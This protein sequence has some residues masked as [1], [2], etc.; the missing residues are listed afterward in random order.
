MQVD[1]GRHA[2]AHAGPVVQI[3]FHA[4]APGDGFQMDHRVGR[5][6]DRRVDANS[7]FEGFL[8]QDLRQFQV[9][10]DH[11]HGTHAGHVRQHIAARIHGW[12]RRVVG[13][14]SAE[15]F[16][17]AGHGRGGAHGVAGTGRAG[18]AALGREEIVDADGAGLDL[19]A[20]LPDHGAGANVLALVLAVEHRPA[21]DDDGR[22]VAT[23]G[24]HQ[25]GRGGLVATGQQYDAVNRVAANGFF[26][27]HA[28][29]VAGEHG[30]RAQVRFAVGEHRKL[31]R[32]APGFDYPALDVLRNLAEVRVARGQ[33][34][35]GVADADDRLAM[36]LVVGD[37][38]ILHPAAVHE[39]V[40]VGGAKPLGGAQG[41]FL[42]RHDLFSYCMTILFELRRNISANC[43]LW[44][45]C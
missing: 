31:H 9:F 36:E 16:S 34:R 33:F 19:F 4:D 35:P 21:G 14:G 26:H 29:Q 10:A 37:A 40:L 24:A 25:Q 2:A 45:C 44:K 41:G 32:E 42:I 27:V 22:H 7:V 8:G 12:N 17:H 6:A 23:G 15:G 20:E 13:Q 43:E 28:R 5:T 3:Q 1:D 11:L 18:H 39:A 30:G 38:L